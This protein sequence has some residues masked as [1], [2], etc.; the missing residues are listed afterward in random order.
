MKALVSTKHGPLD[1]LQLKEVEKP[2]PKDNQVLIKVIAK[3]VTSGDVR[4]LSLTFPC[5]TVFRLAFG[6]RIGVP[7]TFLAPARPG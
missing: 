1:V 7:T 2:T 3:T 6:I 4:I 5:A